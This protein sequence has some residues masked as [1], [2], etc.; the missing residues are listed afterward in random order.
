MITYLP[1][2]IIQVRS[3]S[4]PAGLSRWQSVYTED[5]RS[6]KVYL[7]CEKSCQVPCYLGDIEPISVTRD[8]MKKSLGFKERTCP[9][10]GRQEWTKAIKFCNK[11]FHLVVEDWGDSSNYPGRPW[12]VH[13]D[14]CD[15]QSVGSGCFGYLHE[16][17]NLVFGVTGIMLTIKDFK[18]EL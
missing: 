18:Q 9:I 7:D 11:E 15:M 12:Y 4:Y 14:N 10:T 8:L 13:F 6:G 17:Q 5:T 16:F 2:N 3:T 1:G